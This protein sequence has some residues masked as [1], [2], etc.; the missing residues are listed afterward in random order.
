MSNVNGS[1]LND[2]DCDEKHVQN[3]LDYLEEGFPVEV[4][5][6]RAQWKLERTCPFCG[7]SRSGLRL[8]VIV[9]L[10][11]KD[12]DEL[13]AKDLMFAT[14]SSKPYNWASKVLALL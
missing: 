10:N 2:F 14:K 3:L 6:Q 11:W 12:A 7:E 8:Y 1:L 4:V 13:P 9:D 5:S